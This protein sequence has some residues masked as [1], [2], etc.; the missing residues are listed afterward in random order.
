MIG[1]YFF[2]IFNLLSRTQCANG[3]GQVKSSP[4]F[5]DIGRCQVY[6]DATHGKLK[7]GIDD[8]GADPVAAFAHGGVGLGL[9]DRHARQLSL[10]L[11]FLDPGTRYRVELYRDGEG[12]DW[13]GDA[14][15]RF[16]REERTLARGDVLDVW[17][18]GGGGAAVRLVPLAR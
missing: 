8:G 18:A 2:R 12:A 7:R 11:D 15:F 3:N 6:R 5:A 13:K 17:L 9:L 1:I 14:R 16:V 4:G 10:T